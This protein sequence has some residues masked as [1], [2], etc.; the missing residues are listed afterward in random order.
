MSGTAGKVVAISISAEKGVPKTNVESARLIE[1][2]GIEGDAHAGKWHRQLSLLFS[3]QRQ[4]TR[5]AAT[6]SSRSRKS[7]K[8]AIRDARSTSKWAIA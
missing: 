2:A 1:D 7:A 6:S 4:R 3:T 5:S 8:N